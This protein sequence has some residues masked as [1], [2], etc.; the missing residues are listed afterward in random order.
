MLT[1]QRQDLAALATTQEGK[2]EY[3]LALESYMLSATAYQLAL[4][5]LSTSA[6]ATA[7]D[8]RRQ[9]RA[10]W[11]KVLGRAERIKA[12][13]AL[14]RAGTSSC[15]PGQSLFMPCKY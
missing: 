2:R 13:T 7:V 5:S 14:G 8:T 6:S 3:G 1:I 11:A 10:Q 9:L 15:S 12:S 4:A